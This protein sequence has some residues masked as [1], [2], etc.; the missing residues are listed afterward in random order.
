MARF[1]VCELEDGGFVVICQSPLLDH[2]DVRFAMPLIPVREA[3]HP[4]SR[5]NPTIEFDGDQFLAFPQW[6]SGMLASDLKRVR[7]NVEDQGLLILDAFDMLMS[8][9]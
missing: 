5:L 9:I 7:G 8:G 3:P 6:S 4:A 1:D 2:L